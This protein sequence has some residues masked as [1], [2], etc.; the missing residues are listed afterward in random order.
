MEL[1]NHASWWSPSKA[2]M[3]RWSLTS[4]TYDRWSPVTL[5]MAAAQT[6]P[7]EGRGNTWWFRYQRKAVRMNDGQR[8]HHFGLSAPPE[9]P[10]S[11][12]LAQKDQ[13]DN[14]WC[15]C[16]MDGSMLTS[17]WQQEDNCVTGGTG[18]R[19]RSQKQAR[20]CLC[21][22]NAAEKQKSCF[23]TAVDK[24]Y[25]AADGR[26]WKCWFPSDW[27]LSLRIQ[28]HEYQEGTEF[29]QLTAL[30]DL[31]LS[32]DLSAARRYPSI[33]WILVISA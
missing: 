5:N 29:R 19:A 17:I 12:A 9:I 25:C 21:W 4:R 22:R 32:R 1:C 16:C 3:G 13:H 27:V 6:A 8:W 14:C 18:R 11:T 23:P 10:W 2:A 30:K 26:S 28:E 7:G 15:D 24:P 31:T 33:L 20:H